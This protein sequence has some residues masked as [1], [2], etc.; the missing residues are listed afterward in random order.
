MVDNEVILQNIVSSAKIAF[1]SQKKD[2]FPR[3]FLIR[4]YHVAWTTETISFLR[5]IV[6]K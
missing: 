6:I 3:Q 4:P 1:G 5:V 2:L